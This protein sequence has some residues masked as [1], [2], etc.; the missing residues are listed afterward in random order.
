MISSRFLFLL[1][2]AALC[3]ASAAAQ[4]QFP[5][6]PTSSWAGLPPLQNAVAMPAPDVAQY[7]AEDEANGHFPFR[8]GAVIGTHLDAR[9]E[10][11]W[12]VASDGTKVWRLEIHSPGAKS[13]GI[14]FSKF[15][16]PA[17]GTLFLYDQQQR[18]VLGAYTELNENPDGQF[19]IQ[20]FA[21]DVAVLEYNEPQDVTRSAEIVV[22]AVIHDY[23]GVLGVLKGVPDSALAGGAD[24]ACLVDIN[25]PQGASWQNHKRAS[26]KTV[27]GGG[28]CSAALINN[29]ANDGT[30]Y[31]ITANHCGQSSNTVFY[32]N[33]ET[34]GCGTGSAPQNQTV[35]GATVLATNGTYD[36]RFMR[37]NNAIPNAYVPYFCG[38]SRSTSGFTQGTSIGHPS[39][40]PKKISIDNNGCTLSST[41][42]NATWNTGLLEG[43]SSGGPIYDQN[44]RFRGQAWFVNSFT[45]GVQTAGYGRFDQFWN[46]VN[47]AQWLAP[48]GG[49]APTTLDAYDP[50]GTPP[51]PPSVTTVSP[52]TV[53]AFE[54]GQVTL[55]G[56]NF[57]SATSLTVGSTMLAPPL[58]FTIVSNTQITF[59]APQ[60]SALGTVN[61]TVTNSIGTSPAKTLTYTETVP[62]KLA[63]SPFGLTGTPLAYSYGGGS[64][65]IAVLVFSGSSTTFPFQGFNVL[66]GAFVLKVQ[67]LSATGLGSFSSAPVPASAIGL[68]IHSQLIDVNELNGVLVGATNPATTSFLF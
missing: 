54:P 15:D 23:R 16:L 34:S 56:T 4:V 25:C 30:R 6:V 14:E 48:G 22:G 61:V 68:T 24:G 51:A 35:S 62:P 8:F 10:G 27:S 46:A 21:G 52:S 36:G 45:C 33:Y 63:V 43:G 47:L 2:P 44:G 3:V 57:N 59:F 9:Q 31:V 1:A 42:W 55:T 18:E 11:Q 38:W 13:L 29:T 5:G 7:M 19:V 37:I 41:V 50:F 53:T 64:G 65:D 12:D 32:F 39:G 66:T 28:L 49:T 58:G 20:P 17:G 26:M 60:P 40:G 67:F